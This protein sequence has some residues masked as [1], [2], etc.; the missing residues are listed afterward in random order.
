[1]NFNL[2]ILGGLSVTIILGFLIDVI[3]GTGGSDKIFIS[4]LIISLIVAGMLLSKISYETIHGYF[5]QINKILLNLL[6]LI[7]VIIQILVVFVI[8][9]LIILYVVAPVMIKFGFYVTMP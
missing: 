3:K 8:T 4:I 7:F 6:S 5:P 1:M 9:A 2:L